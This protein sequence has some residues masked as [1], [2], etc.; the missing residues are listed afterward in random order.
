MEICS[1]PVSKHGAALHCPSFPGVWRL[2]IMI[3]ESG[4]HSLQEIEV[5]GC[6][7]TF[8]KSS[9]LPMLATQGMMQEINCILT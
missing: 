1:T 7:F 3:D 4:R 2:D 6:A 5:V 9:H 8:L